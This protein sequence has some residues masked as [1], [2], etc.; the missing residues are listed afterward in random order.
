MLNGVIHVL[1]HAIQ[2]LFSLRP[3]LKQSL[4]HLCGQRHLKIQ[5]SL[6]QLC[7]VR[8]F[9]TANSRFQQ[10][11]HFRHYLLSHSRQRTID[12]LFGVLNVVFLY[13][14]PLSLMVLFEFHKFLGQLLF[15][16]IQFLL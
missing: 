3:Q 13:L 15:V 6:G 4:L 16:L 14:L 9:M 2:T 1:L 5:P 12:I 10:V 8:N 7:I 11:L